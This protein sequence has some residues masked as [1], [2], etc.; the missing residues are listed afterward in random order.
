MLG[1]LAS[2]PRLTLASELLISGGLLVTFVRKKT[3]RGCMLKISGLLCL[4]CAVL[5]VV[6]TISTTVVHMNRLQTLRECFYRPHVQTCTCLS[7]VMDPV[8]AMEGDETAVARFAFMGTSDCEVVHGALYSCLRGLFGLSV[9]GILVSIFSCMLVYQ[10]MT[11]EKKKA[12]WEQLELRRRSFFRTHP[13]LLLPYPPPPLMDEYGFNPNTVPAYGWPTPFASP[14]DGPYWPLRSTCLLEEASFGHS[15][16]RPQSNG[17]ADHPSGPPL[18][19]ALTPHEADNDWHWLPWRQ[20]S[21]AGHSNRYS[22]HESSTTSGATSA[23]EGV[24]GD[25]AP[26]MGGSGSGPPPMPSFHRPYNSLR[27]LPTSNYDR[28]THRSSVARGPTSASFCVSSRCS[29]PPGQEEYWGPPPPYPA[30]PKT[31][32]SSNPKAVM[33]RD[34]ILRLIQSDSPTGGRQRVPKSPKQ[35]SREVVEFSPPSPKDNRS[36]ADL[37]Q[38][39]R[40]PSGKR[41]LPRS[42]S[43]RRVTASGTEC[44]SLPLKR[45]TDFLALGAATLH[46]GEKKRESIPRLEAK[47]ERSAFRQVIPNSRKNSRDPLVLPVSSPGLSVGRHGNHLKS[48]ATDSTTSSVF[49]AEETSTSSRSS[50]PGMTATDAEVASFFQED[51][52]ENPSSASPLMIVKLSTECSKPRRTNRSR[53]MG[54]NDQKRRTLQ[55]GL[56]SDSEILNSSLGICANGDLGGIPRPPASLVTKRSSFKSEPSSPRRSKSPRSPRSANTRHQVSKSSE[57]FLSDIK[58]IRV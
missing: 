23:T 41:T 2:P 45:K 28:G 49:P 9:I 27:R 13:N 50:S 8:K 35:T 48:P 3:R 16:P 47:Q 32:R 24:M 19:T 57:L 58:S 25:L 43:G 5:C 12:Y 54:G 1:Y 38:L 30:T 52:A 17:R 39:L 29:M 36:P 37:D 31:P 6:V 21:A 42:L 7:A 55:E 11:H 18:H 40:T 10:L 33:A 20:T 56:L 14:T 26:L 15:R 4:L 44:M 51:L 22:L 53:S 34:E 46:E